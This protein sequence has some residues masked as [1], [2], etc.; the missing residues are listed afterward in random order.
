MPNIG[1][2]PRTRYLDNQ[3]RA[4]LPICESRPP[5]R[6]GPGYSVR[7]WTQNTPL[8]ARAVRVSRS[9]STSKPV[10]EQLGTCADH[11]QQAPQCLRETPRYSMS[12]C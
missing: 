2:Y 6:K 7:L 11:E 3:M 10:P 9:A 8:T 5:E 4:P 12:L 1:A